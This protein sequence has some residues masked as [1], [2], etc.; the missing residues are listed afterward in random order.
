MII[1]IRYERTECQNIFDDIKQCKCY[2]YLERH[3]DNLSSGD[4]NRVEASIME[5][6]KELPQWQQEREKQ[7]RE[8]M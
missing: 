6:L 5:L 4:P 2:K 7:E 3:I 8:N 1:P